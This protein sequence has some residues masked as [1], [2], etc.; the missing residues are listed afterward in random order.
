MPTHKRYVVLVVILCL[1]FASAT[2]VINLLVD[3]LWFWK[4]NQLTGVNFSFNER[5]A[6]LNHLLAHKKDFDCIIFGSSR[7]T[8]FQADSVP[9]YRCF[10]IGFSGGRV[11]EYLAFAEYLASAGI[12]PRLVIVGVD[13]Y[14]FQ[15][16][17]EPTSVPD[18]VNT[19]SKPPGLFSSYLTISA[20]WF[21]LRTLLDESPLPRYYTSRFECAIRDDAPDF[22]PHF[23][24][25][26]E[27]LKRK[28]VQDQNQKK[29]DPKIAAYF[30]N[31]RDIFPE[32]RFVAYVPPVSAWHIAKDEKDGI[33]NGYLESIYATSQYFEVFWD[34]SIP[35]QVTWSTDKTY[36]GSHYDVET[37]R[38]I[39][40][41]IFNRVTGPFGLDMSGITFGNY[42]A[43]YEVALKM[44]GMSSQ[45]SHNHLYS[46]GM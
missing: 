25:E 45:T 43:S 46:D 2:L 27:G 38:L 11:K 20:L 32:A 33:L 7:A 14:N 34:F 39:A 18:Y 37:N 6:K 28:G 3:P 24:L 4:G 35:S 26:A 16:L 42:V 15:L 31:M 1:L 29:Y 10:N 41:V 13:G 17:D 9:G 8:L 5:Q 36:D 23:P 40:Q 22:Q 21:S 44:F 19:K 12:N 30:G